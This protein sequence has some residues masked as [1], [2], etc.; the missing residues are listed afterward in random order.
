VTT[1]AKGPVRLSVDGDSFV[2]LTIH[3]DLT[4]LVRDPASGHQ[5]FGGRFVRDPDTGRIH[6]LQV[7]GRLARR[8]LFGQAT[9]RR[10]LASA[11]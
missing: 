8:Q 11:G 10:R 9:A 7:G 1:G 5:V 6:G 4:F 2:P 3:E